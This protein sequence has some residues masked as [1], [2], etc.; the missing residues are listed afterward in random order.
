MTDLTWISIVF[1]DVIVLLVASDV[2]HVVEDGAPPDDFASR[3]V[4][5]AV[6]EPDAGPARLRLSLVLPVHAAQLEVSSQ[7][8][9]VGDLRLV[10]A[11]LQQ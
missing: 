3:P 5:A 2:E 10:A 9:N 1:P 7:G 4:A 6:V 11:S 8:G